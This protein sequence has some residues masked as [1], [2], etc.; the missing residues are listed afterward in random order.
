MT[1]FRYEAIDSSGVPVHGVVEA[2]DRAALAKHIETRGLQ[3]VSADE[4]SL[5]SLV[6]ANKASV[7]RLF[8][9][10]VGEQLR[11]AL[12]TGLPAHEAVRAIAAEPLSHPVPGLIPWAWGAVWLV[13]AVACGCYWLTGAFGNAVA[14]IGCFGVFAMPVIALG[15]RWMFQDRPRRTLRSLADRLE[16]GEALPASLSTVMPQELRSVMRSQVD[17]SSK[18]RV[19]ADLIPGLLGGNLRIQQFVM[20]LVGPVLLMGLIGMGMYSV[21]L[22]IM[23]QFKKIFEDFGTELPGMTLLVINLS[24]LIASA[25]VGGWFI[26]SIVLVLVVIGLAMCLASHQGA[27]LLE[28]IP[29]FGMAFRWAM[30]ARVAR[31][32]SAMIR[33]GCSYPESLQTATAGS[34]FASVKQQGELLA[35]ELEAKSGVVIPARKLSGLPISM[36]FVEDSQQTGEDRRAIVAETF[37]SLAEMLDSA[38]LGQGRLFAL[39]LQF[40]TIVFTGIAIAFGVIAMFLPLIKLLNDLS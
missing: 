20:T 28:K 27:E 25:G 3:L 29:V 31:V 6:V 23:P 5:D 21:L 1:Q 15:V 37:R 39:I 32:L 17:D 36:L 30:Q 38:T 18:A 4:V 34:G 40:C 8:Q 13:F 33:N 26:S 22:F 9:L 2:E 19:A 7:P 12:L 16:S 10:R 11:E 14:A 35:K 24:D